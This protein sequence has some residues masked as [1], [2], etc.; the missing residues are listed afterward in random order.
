MTQ[1][2]E[3]FGTRAVQMDGRRPMQVVILTQRF[4]SMRG[5]RNTHSARS[6]AHSTRCIA[7][8]ATALHP[9]TENNKAVRRVRVRAREDEAKICA[10]ER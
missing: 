8:P 4:S 1:S 7:T 3:E 9:F 5:D 10:W 6:V 2:R